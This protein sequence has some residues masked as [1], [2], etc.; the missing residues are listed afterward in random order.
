MPAL[1]TETQWHGNP[2]P[3]TAYMSSVNDGTVESPYHINNPQ[4]AVT[5]HY[6]TSAP[7][8]SLAPAASIDVAGPSLVVSA[9]VD[10]L[11]APGSALQ[12]AITVE[13]GTNIS[14]SIANGTENIYSP[15][16][17]AAQVA[18]VLNTLGAG[19]IQ[20]GSNGNVVGISALAGVTN[21]TI[22][23]WAVAP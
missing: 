6:V 16:Q 2:R 4:V 17:W 18:S 14:T 15:D 5:R 19:E 7:L 8:S 1:I 23:T 3:I 22:T 11:W 12:I 9:S 20:C 10:G 13:G 21:L